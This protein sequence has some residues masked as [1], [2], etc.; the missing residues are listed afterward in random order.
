MCNSRR[1][2]ADREGLKLNGTHELLVC[3]D[4]NVFGRSVHIVKKNRE[5]LLIAS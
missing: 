1:V 2:E 4:V 3:A 5:D